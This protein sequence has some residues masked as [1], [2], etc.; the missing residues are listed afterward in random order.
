MSWTAKDYKEAY[1][2]GASIK[3]I[4]LFTGKGYSTIRYHLLKAG[5]ELRPRNQLEPL[6]GEGTCKNGHDMTVEGA[7]NNLGQW[8]CK[9]CKRELV[10]MRYHSDEE[11]RENRLRSS[12]EWK[13]RL[14]EAV[15]GD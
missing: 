6:T 8:Y 2:G 9:R 4:A 11:F 12:R 15:S 10:K 3:E 13:E 1:E 7:M 14:R 5:T